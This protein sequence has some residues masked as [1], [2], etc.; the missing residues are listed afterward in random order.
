MFWNEIWQNAPQVSCKGGM[1]S[2]IFQEC[3]HK[4]SNKPPGT[5]QISG[6]QEGGGGLE[7]GRAY[8]KLFGRQ[9]QNCTMSMES[10]MLCS[11]NNN[12]ELLCYIVNTI[13]N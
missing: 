7:E 5:Y 13:K 1:S 6:P 11:F 2:R 4:S 12:Y 3:Y 10:E 8:L 9:R